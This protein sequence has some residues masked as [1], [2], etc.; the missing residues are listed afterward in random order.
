M[1]RKRGWPWTTPCA[2]PG[3]AVR[4]ALQLPTGQIPCRPV[5]SQ[6][7]RSDCT[8][9]RTIS[10]TSCSVQRALH[11]RCAPAANRTDGAHRLQGRD[12]S[13]AGSKGNR[14]TDGKSAGP[15]EERE[16]DRTP[17]DWSDS[18]NRRPSK[19]AKERRLKGE[20]ACTG[21][22]SRGRWRKDAARSEG[23]EG[24]SERARLQSEQS[25]GERQGKPRSDG[26]AL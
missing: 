16:R 5:Q 9:H 11:S 26:H 8:E 4:D 19:W 14:R 13:E 25:E 3:E 6:A 22:E 12:K 10:P 7:K 17:K 15:R 2:E 1:R 18:P 20:R 24:G 23:S 21:A